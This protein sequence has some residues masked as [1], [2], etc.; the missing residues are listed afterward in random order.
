MIDLNKISRIHIVGIG[1]IGTSAI[2]RFFS[3]LGKVVS[4]SD[5][6][7]SSNTQDLENF[8]VKVN[9]GHSD[10]YLD[11]SIDLLVYTEDI[12]PDSQGYIEIEKAKKLQIPILSYAQALGCLM[13]GHYGI[14]ITGTNGKS[15]TAAILGLILDHAGLDPA[16]IIGSKLSEINETENFHANARFGLGKYFVCEADEY[17]RH[18][19]DGKPQMIVLTNIAEDHLDYYKDL[20]DIKAAFSDYIASLPT[21]GVVIYN[22]DDHNAVEVARNAHCHKIT[23]GIHHYADIQAVNLQVKDQKQHFDVHF[24]DELLFSCAVNIPGSYNISNILGA[25]AS[26]LRLEVKPEII[27]QTLE[28]FVGIWRRFERVGEVGGKPVYSDYGHHPAAITG[29][30][31]AV[32]DFYPDKKVLLVFQ[33]HHHNRTK[34]LFGEFAEAL[35]VSANTIVPEIFD[36]AGRENQNDQNISSLDLVTEIKKLG[37]TAEYVKDLD[38]AKVRVLEIIQDYDAV[39]FMGA[40]D[41]DNLARSIIEKKDGN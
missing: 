28:K 22:A 39:I 30:L 17:H 13:D 38:T 11:N 40:G 19:M 9:I 24:K 41:I 18:M 1:G 21:D 2:A 16:V 26:A 8:G 4:G 27:K 37:G 3:K 23:F 34:R 15:T 29:V 31:S 36:V 5:R 35:I 14:G 32:K 33:P 25:V 6:I 12:T 20:S 7:E 10:N